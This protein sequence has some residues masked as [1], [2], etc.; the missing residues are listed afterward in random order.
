M[1]VAGERKNGELDRQGEIRDNN[2]NKEGKRSDNGALG[3]SGL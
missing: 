3:R 2:N 1:D